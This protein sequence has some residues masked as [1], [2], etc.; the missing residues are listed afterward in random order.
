[1][2]N[3]LTCVIC[4]FDVVPCSC[5]A[6]EWVCNGWRHEPYHHSHGVDIGTVIDSEGLIVSEDEQEGDNAC[7]DANDVT[8]RHGDTQRSTT[9]GTTLLDERWNR[10]SDEQRRLWV[11]WFA[12]NGSPPSSIPTVLTLYEP[13]R[14]ARRKE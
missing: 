2:S 9:G 12:E 5:G 1:M 7:H 14:R 3:R 13:V 11:R 6:P 4:G 10:L 8:N